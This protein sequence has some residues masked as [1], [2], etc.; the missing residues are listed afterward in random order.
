MNITGQTMIFRNDKGYSTTISN[1]K[2]DGTYENMFISVNFKKGIEVENK[3]KIN[4]VN[5]FLTFYTN[6]AGNKIPKLVITDFEGQEEI[7]VYTE[8]IDDLPF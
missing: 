8:S 7:P 6:N 1:K 4:I 2:E 3:T 5:G